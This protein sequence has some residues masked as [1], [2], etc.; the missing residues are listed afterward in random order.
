MIVGYQ[1][2]S[3][4]SLPYQCVAKKTPAIFDPERNILEIVTSFKNY[5]Y[6]ARPKEVISTFTSCH[7]PLNSACHLS[8]LD[9]SVSPFFSAYLTIRICP[10]TILY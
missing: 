5:I 8:H 6:S 4:D 2:Y 9:I 3:S 1:C 7:R 10:D